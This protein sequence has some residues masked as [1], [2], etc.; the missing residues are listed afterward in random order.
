MCAGVPG[1]AAGA[2]FTACHRGDFNSDT[3]GRLT[4]EAR[5]YK[6]GVKQVIKVKLEHPDQSRW[7]FQ[8]TIRLASNPLQGVGT[9][10]AVAGAIRVVCS[11]GAGVARPCPEGQ[12]EFATHLAPT[13]YAGQRNG[14]EWEIAWTPPAEA[15]GDLIIYAAGNAA[16]SAGG[17]SGDI[18]YNVNRTI[19]VENCQLP[20]PAIS[21]VRNAASFLDGPLSLNTLI[22]IGGTGLQAA[23]TTRNV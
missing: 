22:A 2:T 19:G 14:G 4:I 21:A 18:I 5:D 6:P 20:K 11:A 12:N 10:T 15:V 17:N 16:N 13:T 8:L 23:G 9:F 7:G 1:E 3:R